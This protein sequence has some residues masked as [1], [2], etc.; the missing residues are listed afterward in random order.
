MQIQK[1]D[2]IEIEF[3][4]RVKGGGIFDSNI[5]EDLSKANMNL[6]AKPF[7]FCIGQGMFL[8]GVEN[9]LI[10]K[11]V[12]KDYKIELSPE[13]AFGNRNPSFVKI[14]PKRIFDSHKINPVPGEMLNFDN[15]IGKVLTV[16]GGRVIIDFNNPLAGKFV[17]Y[18]VKVLRKVEEINEK[19]K[20]FIEFLFK[21]DLKFIIED[22]KIVL[23]VDKPFIQF[24]E[25]FK[26]KFNEI[27]NLELEV[28]ESENNSKTK[29][30][31]KNEN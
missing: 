1:K 8:E 21:K 23:E 7:I 13:K 25:L 15:Q 24:A 10:N 9:F 3:T 29:E 14:M 16:S 12:G 30:E 17:I 20:A 28:K 18:D 19:I 22:K 11:E 2:F 6:P 31:N 27:F 4:G 5:K 26:P